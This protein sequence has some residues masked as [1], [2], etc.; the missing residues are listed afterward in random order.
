MNKLI[1]KALS[2]S[3]ES[4]KDAIGTTTSML[5]NTHD[6]LLFIR[7]NKKVLT[8]SEVSHKEAI[9]QAESNSDFLDTILH[10]LNQA[11]TWQKD[12]RSDLEVK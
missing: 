1:D 7:E 9:Q 8:E 6:L 11:I 5:D 12:I 10:L 4:T 2:I 3:I